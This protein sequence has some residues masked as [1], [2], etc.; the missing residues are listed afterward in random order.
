MKVLYSELLDRDI[1]VVVLDSIL[2]SLY[3]KKSADIAYTGAKT[4]D[5]GR[6]AHRN[7]GRKNPRPHKPI[8][9]AIHTEPVSQD[10]LIGSLIARGL[11]GTQQ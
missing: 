7:M 4:R 1:I 5:I 6:P 10:P 2:V 8:N 9:K 11:K 3:H